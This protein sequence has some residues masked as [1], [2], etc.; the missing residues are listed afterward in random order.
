MSRTITNEDDVIDSRDV[1][2]AIEDLESDISSLEEELEQVRAPGYTAAEGQIE[3]LEIRLDDARTELAP[4]KAL[5][6]QGETCADWQY[7]CGLIRESYFTDHI[8]ELVDDCYSLPKGFDSS[9]W[10]WRHMTM[11]WESAAEE[12]KVDYTEIDFDGVTYYVR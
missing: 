6:E 5:A 10:P 2:Q 8:K 4:L 12:A 9:A 11:D 3:E 7:G 1:I